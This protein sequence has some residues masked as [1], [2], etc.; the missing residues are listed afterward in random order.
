M[1]AARR[2]SPTL[3]P[4]S[5]GP[6]ET[7]GS[8]EVGVGRC[9]RIVV[10]ASAAGTVHPARGPRGPRVARRRR[11]ERRGT[12]R[13]ASSALASTAGSGGS[14]TC[15]GSEVL[16]RGRRKLQRGRTP[17]RGTAASFGRPSGVRTDSQEE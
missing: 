11:E 8:R 15:Y 6:R 12:L 13:G 17:K 1:T 9:R 14:R 16:K 4:L 7:C 2:S 3:S 10:V 5:G